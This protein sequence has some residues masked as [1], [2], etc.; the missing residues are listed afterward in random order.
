MSNN[1]DINP[2]SAANYTTGKPGV[3]WLRDYTHAS[4]LYRENNYALTPKAGFLYFVDFNINKE[5][6]LAGWDSSV[7]GLLAKNVQLPKFKITTETVNQ[8]NRKTNIQTKINYEPVKLEFHDDNAS[9]TNGLWKNYFKY[10]Y[11]DPGYAPTSKT[12]SKQFDDTKFNTIDYEYG[13]QNTSQQPFF[14]SIDIYILHQGYYTKMSL[15]N[16][17]ISSWD[18][19]TL[20]Q[21][22]GNKMLK[23]SMTL[24]YEDVFYDRGFIL[25]NSEASG[26]IDNAHYDTSSST[27][28]YGDVSRSNLIEEN[29]R[30]NKEKLQVVKPPSTAYLS[31]SLKAL[32]SALRGANIARQ[33]LSNPKQAWQVYGFNPKFVL[34]NALTD[35]VFAAAA[36]VTTAPLTPQNQVT[37]DL[38][39]PNN[40]AGI[41]PIPNNLA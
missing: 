39:I 35:A 14:S 27:L 8:Y 23:N 4:K 1:N 40:D 37:P 22:E 30:G 12:N 13:Y 36:S 7:I 5:A 41:S 25:A 21:T 29:F 2:A 6:K 24:V 10:Y 32:G 18:H 26:F 19:D 20:D 33:L 34:T 3:P 31:P 11:T 16:P 15:I 38:A 17:L 9:N 28:D